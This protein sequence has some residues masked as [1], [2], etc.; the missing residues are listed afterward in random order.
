MA[1]LPTIR[2]EIFRDDT[3]IGIPP[4]RLPVIFALFNQADS[5]NNPYEGAGLGLYIVKKYSELLGGE[6]HVESE[7]RKGSTFRFAL[8]VDQ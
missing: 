7:A 8:P 1:S 4:D 2:C 5:S 3:G 6:V